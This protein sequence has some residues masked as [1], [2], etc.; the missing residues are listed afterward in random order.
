MILKRR[1]SWEAENTWTDVLKTDQGCEA[2]SYVY[3][4][5]TNRLEQYAMVI[6]AEVNPRLKIATRVI[7]ER[8]K[9]KR[10]AT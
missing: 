7:D 3:I 8:L 4:N 2:E 10:V 6:Q 5:T 9:E 1:G